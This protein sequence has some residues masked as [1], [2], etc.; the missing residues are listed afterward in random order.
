[1]KTVYEAAN[2]LEAHMLADVLRQE[3]VAAQVMGSYLPGAMGE[4]PAAGLVR[5][6]VDEADFERARAAIER[7]EANQVSDPLPRANAAATRASWR[8]G[9]G[10]LVVGAG[11]CWAWL[12]VPVG[13]NEFDH[14][15]D[16]RVDER[17][18]YSA[19]NFA[20]GGEFD[21]NFDGRM[22]LVYRYDA[23]GELTSAE[24]DGDFDGVFETLTRFRANQ[25]QTEEVDTDGDSL[26]DS[27][28]TFAFGVLATTQYL[29]PRSGRPTRIDVYR[30]GRLDH[31][32]R[33]ADL[34]GVL[35]IREHYNPLGQLT[36][37]ERL[38][39]PS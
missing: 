33:D 16:G 21:R 30:L 1:M 38:A 14:N 35:D 11:L 10:G 18:T 32:D 2:A 37:T 27:V 31:V 7:W 8:W 25:A 15:R 26:I 39:P 34:D 23:Q 3:G 5:L 4:L 6:D 36:R 17:W 20:V 24:G 19:A 12:H 9:L 13:Q 29:E 28:S 22:D